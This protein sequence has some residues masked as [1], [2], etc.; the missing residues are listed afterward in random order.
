[1]LLHIID[2]DAAK[3][4]GDNRELIR[5][6]LT[7]VKARVGGGVRAAADAAAL[8]EMGA[9]QVIVGSAVFS[10]RSPGGGVNRQ[11]LVELSEAIGRERIVIAIDAKGGRIAVRGWQ[12]TVDA[13]PSEVMSL[14]EPYCAGFLCT[15][16]DRE[17]MMQ[18]TNVDFFFALRERTENVLIAAGGITTMEEVRALAG[19]G[20]EVALGMA[21]YTGRL[22]LTEL[23]KVS[24]R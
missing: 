24:N 14:L 10:A 15:Y 21:V 6:L 11:F 16:V 23:A 9:S 3:G 12:D 22:S 7:K 5:Y 19:A 4:T 13:T 1:P 2:L 20:I 17:G 18:G 8:V